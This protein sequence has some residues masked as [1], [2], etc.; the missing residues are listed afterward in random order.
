M[1]RCEFHDKNSPAPHLYCCDDYAQ[2]PAHFVQN[3]TNLGGKVVHDKSCPLLSLPWLPK[4]CSGPWRGSCAS[5]PKPG[6]N[7]D[8]IDDRFVDGHDKPKTM[9]ADDLAQI[10]NRIE[11]HGIVQNNK[12]STRIGHNGTGIDQG[13]HLK[14]GG[15]G[16]DVN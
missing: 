11:V 10:H 13:A 3:C 14:L 12:N 1:P 7:L 6:A 2:A 15:A 8:H 4:D 16:G 9:H 5:L